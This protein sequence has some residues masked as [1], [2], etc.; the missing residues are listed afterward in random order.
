MWQRKR[1]DYEEFE[2]RSANGHLI[3]RERYLLAT[4]HKMPVRHGR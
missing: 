2:V 4:F 3:R 1:R